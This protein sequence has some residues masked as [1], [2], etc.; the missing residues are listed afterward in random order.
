MLPVKQCFHSVGHLYWKLR[1]RLSLF[2]VGSAVTP[3]KTEIRA[4]FRANFSIR[5]LSGTPEVFLMWSFGI[6]IFILFYLTLLFITWRSPSCVICWRLVLT[7]MF[8]CCCCYLVEKYLN[9]GLGPTYQPSECLDR[10]LWAI[11]YNCRVIVWIYIHSRDVI[12]FSKSYNKASIII[13]LCLR[14]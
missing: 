12:P 11:L 10:L 5:I 4:V 9:D 13:T 6:I 1:Y 14:V 2:K 8:S 3:S 7:H